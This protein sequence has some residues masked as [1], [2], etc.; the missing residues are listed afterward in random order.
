M[1]QVWEEYLHFSI[2]VTEDFAKT[3]KT[4]LTGLAMTDSPAS[5][6]TDEMR[7]KS[8]PGRTFTAKYPGE[9]VPDL[10]GAR[11][12]D[13]FRTFTDKFFS[14][15][16]H[17][18]KNKEEDDMKKEDFEVFEEELRNTKQIISDVA[19]KLDKF[20]AEQ[21]TEPAQ[22]EE[23]AQP[24]TTTTKEK[25]GEFTELEDQIKTLGEKFDKIVERLEKA[26]PST[27]HSSDSAVDDAPL[28]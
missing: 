12:E 28:L 2:E 11:E 6:G 10:R 23:P 15:L 13:V 3:G 19:E 22:Q 18:S 8:F 16:K 14:F 17:N 20:I 25:P 21:K 27:Q 26:A 24:E 7:F 1:N 9:P 5:L 4:Y